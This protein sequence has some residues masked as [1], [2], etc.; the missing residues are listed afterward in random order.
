MGKRMLLPAAEPLDVLTPAEYECEGDEV[1]KC[2]GVIRNSDKQKSAVIAQRISDYL[3]IR[4][5]GCEISTD[6]DGLSKDCECALVLG[7]DG[8]LLRASKA[9]NRRQLPLL[10]I[11]LGTL[12]YLAEIDTPNLYPAL[13]HLIAGDY[14]VERRMML[15][16]EV[17]HAGEKV[18][19]DVALND[20]VLSRN[21][22]IRTF[23]FLNYV[24]SEYLNTYKA[25]GV[26]VCTPTGSTGYSL[27]VGGPIVSPSAELMVMTPVASH[28]LISRSII[29]PGQDYVRV[30]IGEGRTGLESDVAVVSFDGNIGVHLGTGD[31]VEIR[32]S[33]S[34]ASIIKINNV[35]FVEV[36]RKKMASE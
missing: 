18:F 32:R 3:G 19:S 10:G 30:E 11:N 36:L 26:I 17:F 1:M 7:G 20:I 21:A 14:T 8:T 31:S 25:D 16:G 4:G 29:L 9:V 15:Y 6:G 33:P 24:N 28:S 12:G 5:I 2:I 27:S 13:D 35:S 22:P 34:Y 23:S